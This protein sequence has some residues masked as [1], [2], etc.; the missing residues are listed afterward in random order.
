MSQLRRTIT[1]LL[2][3]SAVAGA[4]WLGQAPAGASTPTAADLAAD[5]NADGELLV[6]KSVQYNGGTG[7]ITRDCRV[8]MAPGAQLVLTKVTL[9]SKCC[10][11]VIS[12]SSHDTE[13]LVIDSRTD[14]AGPLQL[15]AGCCAGEPGEE[16]GHVRVE[17]SFLVASSIEVGASVNNPRGRVEVVASRLRTTMPAT[18]PSIN[19]WASHGTFGGSDGVAFVSG[20]ELTSADR[21]RIATGSWGS[22]TARSNTF[23]APGAVVL[24]T[25]PGGV[26]ATFANVPAVPCT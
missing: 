24:T 12:G 7:W 11:F 14:L 9:L 17:R 13:V 26:C 8:T 15:V 20:S 16:N 23:T 18:A 22:T 25:G 6:P 3:T 2:A 4:L 1:A 21:I 10:F 19:I 5:C